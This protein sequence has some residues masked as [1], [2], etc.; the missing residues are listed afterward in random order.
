MRANGRTVLKPS[1]D[2]KSGAEISAKAPYPWVSRAGL[3]LDYALD[4]FGISAKDRT[5]IDLGASTG[6]FTQ[7]LLARGASKVYAVDVGTAQLH[8]SLHDDLRIVS[9]ENRDARTL[10]TA[11]FSAP[12]NLIVCDVSFISAVKVLPAAMDVCSR[13]AELITLVKPQFEVGKDGIGKGGI[14]RDGE[15]AKAALTRTI[16]WITAQGWQVKAS[17]ISPIKGGSGNT[18]YLLYAASA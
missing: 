7:V 5:C 16:E 12:F 8:E 13:P 18:E 11:D 15:L 14:V 10:T 6:G 3:K 1:E 17:D 4:K 2:I 9:M